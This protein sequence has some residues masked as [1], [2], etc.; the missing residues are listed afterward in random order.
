M[1]KIVAAV[2]VVAVSSSFS[3]V[4]ARAPVARAATPASGTLTAPDNGS[5]RL[6]YRGTVPPGTGSLVTCADGVNA[7]VFTVTLRGL[8]PAFYRTHRALLV[9]HIEWDPRVG[10][11]S[12]GGSD[13]ALVVTH[14]GQ[15]VGSSDGGT[16]EE[17]VP[18]DT[19]APGVYKIFACAFS[20][21]VPQPYRGTVS[22]EAGRVQHLPRSGPSRGLSFMPIT[23]ADP[24]RDLGEPTLRID[25]R[26][27]LYHCGPFGSSRNADYA[28]RS[29]DHGDTYMILGTP[30]EGR[31]APGGGGD[32]D[33]SVAPKK[34]A[35]GNYT[36]SYA[37]LESLT[38]FSTGRSLDRGRSFQGTN[39]SETIPVV[40]RQ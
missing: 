7:D 17:T 4:E 9:A 40:D 13:L 33:L 1:R 22:L 23:V 25:K 11:P 16:S 21:A 29:T 24:Q 15:D 35:Q 2:A 18:V 37:G 6:Q 5:V 10:S 14:N 31:I 30:P 26:G 28:S 39:T 27:T 32:C 36:L 34:N 12:G 8:S 19:P 20:V 3:I 38:N